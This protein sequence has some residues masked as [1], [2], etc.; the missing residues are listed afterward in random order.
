MVGVNSRSNTRDTSYVSSTYTD[1]FRSWAKSW[2]DGKGT[3]ICGIHSDAQDC[4][5][6]A[7][8]DPDPDPNPDPSP[9]CGQELEATL[10]SLEAHNKAVIALKSC[11]ER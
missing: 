7:N 6:S 10:K 8:P 1:K 3:K 11:L 5:G 4:R 2:A 9:D